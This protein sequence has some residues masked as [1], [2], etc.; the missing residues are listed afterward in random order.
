MAKKLV[1]NSLFIIFQGSESKLF[2]YY[3]FFNRIAHRF[4]RFPRIR[5]TAS[6]LTRLS[7]ID[8]SFSIYYPTS[9]RDENH[10]AFTISKYNIMRNI[11]PCWDFKSESR[12]RTIITFVPNIVTNNVY[13]RSYYIVKTRS[14]AKARRIL[15]S[16]ENMVHAHHYVYVLNFNISSEIY[17]LIYNFTI[18]APCFATLIKQFRHRTSRGSAELH[19]N[20]IIIS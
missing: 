9:L 18:L 11:W 13:L 12:R 5:P 19:N 2:N 4:S 10:F 6:K 16:R 14:Q 15:M 8:C 20:N 3:N 7:S 17:Y 1:R